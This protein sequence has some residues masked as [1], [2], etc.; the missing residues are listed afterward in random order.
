MAPLTTKTL[1]QAAEEL[2]ALSAVAM[3]PPLIVL[4]FAQRYIVAGLT[5]GATK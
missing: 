3:L 1:V 4:I 5:F 2:A